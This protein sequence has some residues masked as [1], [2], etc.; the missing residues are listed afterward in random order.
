MSGK[1]NI[2][3]IALILLAMLLLSSGIASAASTPD[4]FGRGLSGVNDFLAQGKN[5][6]YIKIIDF[7][8]FALLFVSIYTIGAVYAFKDFKRAERMI[9]ILLGIMTAF[10]L[11]LAKISVTALLPYVHWI[12]YIL[13][14]ALFFWVLKGMQKKFGRFIMALLLTLAAIWLFNA[15]AEGFTPSGFSLR[16]G[17]GFGQLPSGFM[18]LLN[19]LLFIMAFS[20]I[21]WLMGKIGLKS[22]LAKFLL[23]L[24][25]GLY[26]AWLLG[27]L[28]EGMAFDIGGIKSPIQGEGGGLRNPFAGI[29]KSFSKIKSP[30]GKIKFPQT[31]GFLTTPPAPAPPEAPEAGGLPT[32]PTP[33]EGARTRPLPTEKDPFKSKSGSFYFR[34]GDLWLRDTEGNE[35]EIIYEDG[36]FKRKGWPWNTDL[37]SEDSDS[38]KVRAPPGFF[39]TGEEEQV[40]SGAQPDTAGTGGRTT[41]QQ[42]STSSKLTNNWGLLA[43]AVLALALAGSGFWA[44][45]KGLFAKVSNK[46]ENRKWFKGKGKGAPAG[47]SEAAPES[48]DS[49]IS[50]IDGVMGKREGLLDQM[51]ST[52][53]KKGKNIEE[54]LRLIQREE[55]E[56]QDKGE[57]AEAY[58]MDKD[59]KVFKWIKEERGDIR[60]FL[61]AE[62]EMQRELA[63]LQKTESTNAAKADQWASLIET[64]LRG[65]EF[66]SHRTA[67]RKVADALK[68]LSDGEEG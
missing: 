47:P 50:D 13:L 55:A 51:E 14:F 23:A 54:I 31:P 21:F 43:Y 36:K 41:T 9:A 44:H 19:V 5:N 35:N 8:F 29:T 57:N 3:G 34:G 65:P 12:F 26:I 61:E 18:S 66:E 68:R 22:G 64:N 42:K 7:V 48:I 33:V 67:A 39:G 15:F 32:V 4:F 1:K 28:I 38:L 6:P 20:F 45:K 60:E 46:W 16:A 52:K 40:P 53:G 11:V 59:S 24:A 37:P 58:R 49:M 10:L 2:A 30:F 25:L 63:E 56:L 17:F 62:Q 27:N